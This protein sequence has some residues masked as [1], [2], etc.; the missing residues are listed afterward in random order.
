MASLRKVLARSS[1][2]RS[3]L[4]LKAGTLAAILLALAAPR[5]AVYQTKVAV[6]VLADTSA[7]VSAE[8]LQT[9]SALAG[10]VESARGR[11]WTR[12]IPFARATRNAAAEEHPKDGWRLRHTAGAAGRATDLESAIRDGAASLPAGMVPRLLLISDG[13]EN[14]GSVARAI[15]QAQQ[16]GVPID[17]MPLAGRPKPGLRLESIAIPGQV[18]SGERFPIDV[19]LESPGAAR[20]ATVEMTA[21][22]KSIGASQ[23]ELVPGPNRLRLQ[24]S[25]NSVGAIA[26]AGKI[27]AADLGETRFE[28]AVTLRRPRVLLVSRDPAASEQ[29]L[30]RTLEANQFEVQPAPDRRPGEARRLPARGHQQLG[31]GIH[32]RARARPRSKIS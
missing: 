11:H 28:D 17:T 9:E 4:L 6:A 24:A 27:S 30:L 18:F 23:V 8:D 16:L 19:T 7:S 2:R 22:G 32:S 21:E 26:L 13:N 29:H 20:R 5:I 3:G 10:Q 12:V 14:L 25:V 15:W 31:H 1:A